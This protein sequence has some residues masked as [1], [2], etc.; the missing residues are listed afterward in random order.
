MK[1]ITIDR[2][3]LQEGEL[4]PPIRIGFDDGREE[5]HVWGIDFYTEEDGAHW[6]VKF[7]PA[8]NPLANGRMVWVQ[9]NDPITVQTDLKWG[10]YTT[11]D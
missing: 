2:T 3:W 1:Y 7:D 9:T 6:Q 5:L 10:G 4:K 11:I 8:G